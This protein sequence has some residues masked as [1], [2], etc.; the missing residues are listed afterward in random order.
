MEMAGFDMVYNPRITINVI[1]WHYKTALY[2]NEVVGS[3][4]I[5][6]HSLNNGLFVS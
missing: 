1:P 3:A 4:F 6:L 5:V 2:V